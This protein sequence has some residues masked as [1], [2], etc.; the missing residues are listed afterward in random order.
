MDHALEQQVG[1]PNPR[2][3]VLDM[4]MN[5]EIAALRHQIL[6]LQRENGNLK[7]EVGKLKKA[8][9]KKNADLLFNL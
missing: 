1:M 4:A 5:Q 2:K 8:L 9:K 7:E 3:E 6:V